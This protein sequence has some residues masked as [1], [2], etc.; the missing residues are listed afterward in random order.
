MTSPGYINPDSD[1]R[2]MFHGAQDGLRFLVKW[3]NYSDQCAI[4]LYGRKIRL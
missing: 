4:G 2:L 1:D 3:L